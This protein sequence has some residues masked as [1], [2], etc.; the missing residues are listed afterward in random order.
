M[1]GRSPPRIPMLSCRRYGLYAALGLAQE[2]C[3]SEYLTA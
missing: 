2:G 1:F 3:R